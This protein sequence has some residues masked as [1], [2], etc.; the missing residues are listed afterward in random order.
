MSRIGKIPVKVPKEVK[1]VFENGGVL[2][3]GPKGKLSLRL[4]WGIKVEQKDDQLLVT[5]ETDT[6]QNRANQGTIRAHLVNMI[7]GVTQGHRRDLEIQG[8]GFRAQVQ[9]Q[10]LTLNLGFSHQ[11]EYEILA[12]VKVSTPKPTELVVEGTDIALVGEVAANIRDKKLP[13]PYKGKGIRYLG[14][15]VRRKQG[16]SVTK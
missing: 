12:G 4:P 6:K 8:V 5:R 1:V 11:V 2:I 10:K 15:P 7:T 14:E 3:N 13:E 9:G 16:K